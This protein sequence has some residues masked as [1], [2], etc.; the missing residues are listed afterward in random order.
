MN[1][2]SIVK[3]N[4]GTSREFAVLTMTYPDMD[5]LAI[6]A[7]ALSV[8]GYGRIVTRKPAALVMCDEHGNELRTSDFTAEES[9]GSF[10]LTDSAFYEQI[11]D[12]MPWCSVGDIRFVEVERRDSGWEVV[13]TGR[14]SD[15]GES[16][17]DYLSLSSIYFTV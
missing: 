2:N 15:T 7:S 9:W 3:M 1:I 5:V 11:M 4:D 12:L 13:V 14:N 17:S 6:E 16:D 10:T 8:P